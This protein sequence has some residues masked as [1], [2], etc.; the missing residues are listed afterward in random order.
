[1]PREIRGVNVPSASPAFL[2]VSIQIRHQHHSKRP[3]TLSTQRVGRGFGHL[4]GSGGKT[5]AD[6]RSHPQFLF[7][8]FQSL[9]TDLRRPPQDLRKGRKKTFHFRIKHLSNARKLSTGTSADLRKLKV[10]NHLDTPYKYLMI[11]RKSWPR[12]TLT[13]FTNVATT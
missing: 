4:W 5:S 8:S 11:C 1:M 7:L 6:L 9:A 3:I 12:T 10:I 2:I 13:P